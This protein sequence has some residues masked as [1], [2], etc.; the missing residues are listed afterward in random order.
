MREFDIRVMAV[1]D[2]GALDAMLGYLES[3]P[4]TDVSAYV[5]TLSNL[6]IAAITTHCPEQPTAK[7]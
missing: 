2:Q 4:G 3:H 7:S 6:L 5:D 1:T